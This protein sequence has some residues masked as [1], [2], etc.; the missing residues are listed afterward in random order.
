MTDDDVGASKADS[1]GEK[2]ES[3]LAAQANRA[4]PTH[5]NQDAEKERVKRSKERES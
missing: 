3:T 4:S 2:K 5:S 1:G